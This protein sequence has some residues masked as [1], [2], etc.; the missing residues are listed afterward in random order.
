MLCHRMNSRIRDI[1]LAIFL[2]AVCCS[3]VWHAV[4]WHLNGT[5]ARLH[6]RIVQDGA[7]LPAFYYLGLIVALSLVLGMTM[8]RLISATG[9]RVRRIRHFDVEKE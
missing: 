1:V 5:H 4:S 7:I 9:Y 3:L 8:Q 6:Q 2:A